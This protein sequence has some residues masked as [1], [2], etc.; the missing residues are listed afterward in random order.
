MRNLKIQ[1]AV[2]AALGIAGLAAGGAAQAFPTY[3][4]CIA[5]EGNPAVPKI[6]LAGSSAAQNGIQQSLVNDLFNVYAN[7]TLFKSSGTVN[8]QLVC[9]TAGKANPLVAVGNDILIYYRAEGGSVA[10]ALPIATTS[11]GVQGNAPINQ[12]QLATV[13]QGACAPDGTGLNTCAVTVAGVSVTNGPTDSFGPAG[14]Q[15][16]LVDFGITDVEPGLLGGVN[17][18][19]AY[20]AAVYGTATPAQ[21]SGLSKAAAFSQA[22]GFF[23][24]NSAFTGGAALD[25]STDTIRAVMNGTYTDWNFVPTTSGKPATTTTPAL[26]YIVNRENG[27]GSKAATQNYLYGYGCGASTGLAPT[28]ASLADGWATQ[29]A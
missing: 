11:F 20:N 18:P 19:T 21:L 10:G 14:V 2:S 24:N 12:L 4:Q 29:V 15:K 27:S 25:F 13:P 3:A 5:D 1:A 6:Y 9:G 16:K 23:I 7:V 8:F 17:Y 22:F 26:I 28:A